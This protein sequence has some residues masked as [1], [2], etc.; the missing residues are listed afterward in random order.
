MP[1]AMMKLLSLFLGLIF[2]VDS[3]DRERLGDAREELW[4]VL[5]ADELKSAIL[6]VLANKQDLPNAMSATEI[7]EGLGLH[8]FPPSRKWYVQATCAVNGEGIFEGLD[9][10]GRE[11]KGGK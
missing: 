1:N 6:L 7:T 4:A 11:I 8:K 5:E 10:L 2:V 3:N 9:W